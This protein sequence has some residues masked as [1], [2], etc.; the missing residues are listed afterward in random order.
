MSEVL[1][2]KGWSMFPT[3]VPGERVRVEPVVPSAL[4]PG[5]VAVLY[6]TMTTYEDD[7]DGELDRTVRDTPIVMTHRLVERDREFV[8]TTGDL[9]LT[10][11]WERDPADAVVGRAVGVDRDEPGHDIERERLRLCWYWETLAT[12]VCN[13]RTRIHREVLVPVLAALVD[14]AI[15]RCDGADASVFTVDP[16]PVEDEIELFGDRYRRIVAAWKRHAGDWMS[17]RP[18]RTRYEC[19]HRPDVVQFESLDP[20]ADRSRLAEF[21]RR[22]RRTHS[23]VLPLP[24]AGA[25]IVYPTVSGELSDTPCLDCRPTAPACRRD[26][27]GRRS[28]TGAESDGGS[29][30]TEVEYR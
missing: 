23:T 30:A 13:S 25:S 22:G 1:R 6:G 7:A 12:V 3:V 9:D 4:E 11:E 29:L 18:G 16:V 15:E 19:W 24:P 28:N 26:G 21:C 8:L 10:S 27:T 14:V 2:T 5:E 20:G 17:H